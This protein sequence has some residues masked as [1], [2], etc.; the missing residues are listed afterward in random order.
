M[1]LMRPAAS[2]AVD[3]PLAREARSSTYARALH[4]ACL[5]VGGVPQLAAQLKVAEGALR[6]WLQGSDE[7]PLDVFLAAVEV[8]LLDED[9][10][11]RA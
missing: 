5:I 10:A 11:G 9:G 4:R 3:C 6:G 8:I 2:A 7:P 1:R